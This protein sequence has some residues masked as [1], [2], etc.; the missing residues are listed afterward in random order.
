MVGLNSVTLLCAIPSNSRRLQMVLQQRGSLQKV[1]SKSV[2][3]LGES[4]LKR[5]P[6]KQAV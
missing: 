1:C 2:K 5:P 4:W 6:N 3:S